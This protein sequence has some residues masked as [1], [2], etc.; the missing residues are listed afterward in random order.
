[1]WCIRIFGTFI[2]TRILGLGLVAAWGCMIGH[3]VTLFVL[4]ATYY[5]LGKAIPRGEVPI[6]AK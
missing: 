6:T 2:C 1:M 5:A 3:N 4:F